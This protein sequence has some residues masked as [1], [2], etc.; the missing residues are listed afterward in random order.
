MILEVLII[1]LLLAHCRTDAKYCVSTQEQKL[2]SQYVKELF[3]SIAQWLNGS[4]AQ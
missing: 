4:F 1:T 3:P 2:L